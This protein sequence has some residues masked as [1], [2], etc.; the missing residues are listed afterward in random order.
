MANFSSQELQAK[1][2]EKLRG[3]R[4]LTFCESVL[5]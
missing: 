4:H 2:P 1:D 3:S 5:S